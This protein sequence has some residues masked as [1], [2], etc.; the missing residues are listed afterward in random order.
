[1]SSNLILKHF[2]KTL[3]LPFSVIAISTLNYG[4]DN[5][6]YAIAQ[7]MEALQHQFGEGGP[8]STRYRLPMAWLS[9]FNSLQFIGF[10]SWRCYWEYGKPPMGPTMVYV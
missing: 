2:N 9:L 4:F 10:R 3:A 6:G 1:M 7:A 8:K 5:A